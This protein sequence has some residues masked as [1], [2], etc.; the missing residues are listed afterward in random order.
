MLLIR[1][2]KNIVNKFSPKIFRLSGPSILLTILGLF[3]SW[4]FIH[5]ISNPNL[6]QFSAL[7]SQEQAIL[8]IKKSDPQGKMSNYNLIQATAKSSETLDIY[9]CQ[10]RPVVIK[11]KIGQTLQLRNFDDHDHTIESDLQHQ[12]R[13]SAHSQKEI[14][15]DLGHGPGV[16]SIVCD[17]RTNLSGLFFVSE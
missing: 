14:K 16:Y 6:T 13:V 5:K 3:L 10:V 11:V 7:T 12:Y 17:G 15:V 9:Q 4:P 8:Q 2:I 1:L